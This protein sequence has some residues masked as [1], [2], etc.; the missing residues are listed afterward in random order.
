[1]IKTPGDFTLI[2]CITNQNCFLTQGFKKVG[3]WTKFRKKKKK[4]ISLLLNYVFFYNVSMQDFMLE[5]SDV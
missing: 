1:M 5:K 2:W 4:S 3:R